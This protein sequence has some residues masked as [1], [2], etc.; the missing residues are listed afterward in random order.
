MKKSRTHAD[1]ELFE[2]RSYELNLRAF[3]AVYNASSAFFVLLPTMLVLNTVLHLRTICSTGSSRLG[4]IGSN[5]A[6][7]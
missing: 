7:E 6:R 3:A 2:L 1:C 4:A 5:D